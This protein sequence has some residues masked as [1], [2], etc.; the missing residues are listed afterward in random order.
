M[1]QEGQK[2]WCCYVEGTGG[3]GHKHPTPAEASAEAE[4]L[5]RQYQNIG[6]KVYVLEAE[7]YCIVPEMP[8]EWHPMPTYSEF[9]VDS[10]TASHRP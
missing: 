3:F 9:N 5:A 4:R 6:N 1:V 7:D 10:Q 8:V 2:F